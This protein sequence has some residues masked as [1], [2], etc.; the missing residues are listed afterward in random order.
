MGDVMDVNLTTTDHDWD[1]RIFYSYKTSFFRHA[2]FANNMLYLYITCIEPK[3]LAPKYMCTI[4]V[5]SSQ[6]TKRKNFVI[7]RVNSVLCSFDEIKLS[8]NYLS[9]DIS[10]IK[11]FRGPD[12][13]MDYSVEITQDESYSEN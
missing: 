13:G 3:S 4:T 10:T 8:G 1:L 7:S 12:Y 2:T 9:L 11:A 5:F 6:D